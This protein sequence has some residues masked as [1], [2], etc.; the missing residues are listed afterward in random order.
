M[1]QFLQVV[2]ASSISVVFSGAV[3]FVITIIWNR[4]GNAETIKRF[5]K[6]H[7]EIFHKTDP[8]V[9]IESKIKSLE[10]SLNKKLDDHK[11]TID[12]ERENDHKKIEAIENQLSSLRA[13]MAF[14][15][16]KSGGNAEHLGLK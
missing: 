5:I 7:V 1:S 4:S 13:G 11:N 12:K 6:T 9:V 14:L 16:G 8:I 10:D 3:T 2:V 15:V